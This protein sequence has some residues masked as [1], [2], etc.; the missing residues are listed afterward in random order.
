[1]NSERNFC[2]QHPSPHTHTDLI[3][4]CCSWEGGGV[5]V[6]VATCIYQYH[7]L[8]LRSTNLFIKFWFSWCHRI[9]VQAIYVLCGSV[10]RLFFFLVHHC[11]TFPWKLDIKNSERN[12]GK[13]KCNKAS[14]NN[15]HN[16]IIDRKT[17]VIPCYHHGLSM[18]ENSEMIHCGMPFWLTCIRVISKPWQINW[19]SENC[20]INTWA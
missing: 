1:M 4:F 15:F 7:D 19:G 14:W 10:S 9:K 16:A 11:N 20:V 18:P 3:E 2:S 12:Q 5:G 13:I 6:P 17:P 8:N